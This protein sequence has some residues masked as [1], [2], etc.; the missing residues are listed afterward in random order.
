MDYIVEL[1]ALALASRLRRLID[2]LGKDGT[3]IYRDQKIRFEVR[4]FPIF[5]LL[6]HHAPLAITEIA[7]ALKIKHPSVI[8]TAD[9]M[10]KNGLV[11]SEKDKSDKRY[12]ILK[13]TK[14]GSKLAF[15]LKPIWD[16]FEQGALEAISESKI[17]LLKALDGMEAA[18]ARK[19]V[20]QRISERLK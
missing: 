5:H 10:I 1:G 7:D 6:H 15:K 8:E 12:R 16:A 20:Y 19:G 14:K 3:Q 9:E 13:L 4:W 17:D 2:M 18:M 11:K